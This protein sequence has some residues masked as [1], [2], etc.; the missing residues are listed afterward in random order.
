M[1][2]GGT[3]A[4]VGVVPP[5][6][7]EYESRRCASPDFLASVTVKKVLS[8]WFRPLQDGFLGHVLSFLVYVFRPVVV[9]VNDDFPGR[10][11]Q[12]SAMRVP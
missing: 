12:Q 3:G 7:K 5:D 9:G 4:K 10:Q 11:E 8:L 1:C 6:R 2:G